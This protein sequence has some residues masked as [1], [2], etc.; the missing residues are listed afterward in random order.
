[1]HSRLQLLVAFP[2]ASPARF[3]RSMQEPDCEI[4]TAYCDHHDPKPQKS[5]LSARGTL[6]S[7][8]S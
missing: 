5:G 1:M 7:L 8:W 6:V 4:R 3:S 2:L